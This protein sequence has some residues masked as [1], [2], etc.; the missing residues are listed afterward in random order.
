MQTA[1]AVCPRAQKAFY[2]LLPPASKNPVPPSTSP[3]PQTRTRPSDAPRAALLRMAARAVSCGH[4]PHSIQPDLA[5]ARPTR[6]IALTTTL[7]RLAAVAALPLLVPVSLAAQQPA[8]ATPFD[9]AITFAP[10]TLPHPVNQ[11]RSANGAPGPQYWQNEADYDLHATL[12]PDAKILHAT[13]TITYTNNSPDTLPS[14]WIQLDQNIYRK[15]A[16]ATLINGGAP[17]L[18][19]A[20]R[21]FRREP[22]RPHHGGLRPRVR[23]RRAGRHPHHPRVRHLRHPP[24]APPRHTPRPTRVPQ[25]PY[26]LPLPDPRRLGRPHLL[27]HVKA[28]RNLRHGPV[29]PAHVPST[30]IFAAGTPCPISAASSILNTATSTTTSQCL[31]R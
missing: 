15:D 17:P 25:A 24:P 21:R 2:R 20:R 31:R 23:R 1:A 12:D 10:L 3:R 30:T 19:Q 16:R 4:A 18:A 6:E 28:R 8:P 11:Y 13:E 27:G 7:L 26:R 22:Q 14:L 9:P 5:H 29:V